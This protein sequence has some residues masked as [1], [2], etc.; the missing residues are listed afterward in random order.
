VTVPA[1]V[2]GERAVAGGIPRHTTVTRLLH[3]LQAALILG[4]VALGWWLVDLDYYDRWYND[5]LFWH[6]AL[7]L[8][9]PPIAAAQLAARWR[10]R[11]RELPAVGARWEQ[12]AAAATHRIFLALMF[13][14][15]LT[16]YIISTS[17]GA[18]IPLPGGAQLPA[19]AAIPDPARD[20]AVAAHYWLAYSV[21]ALAAVHAAAALKHHCI[22][23]D[24]ALRRM[25]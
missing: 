25:L 21:A 6:R 1:P 20:F 10:R 15:P 16:G 8:A 23:R 22:D 5:A 13:A 17:A 24:H 9:A 14:I 19:L 11:G 4:L 7:G 18:A 12:A 3:W 2:A